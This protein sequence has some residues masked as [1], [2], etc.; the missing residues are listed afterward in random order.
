MPM[1]KLTAIV[2]LVRIAAILTCYTVCA[3]CEWHVSL[4][5]WHVYTRLMFAYSIYYFS[6]YPINVGQT[7]EV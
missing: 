3:F 4:T 7:K 1:N 2:W 6:Q 5:E